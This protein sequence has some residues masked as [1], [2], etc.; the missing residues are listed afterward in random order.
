MVPYTAFYDANV[1]YPAELRN[2]LMHLALMGVFR[3]RWSAQVHEEWISNLLKQRPDLKR[4]Q[5]DRT[6]ALMDRHA[7]DALVTGY[8]HL[9]PLLTLPDMDDRHILAAA[10]QARADCIVTMNLR[11][12]PREVVSKF[13]IDAQHP[14]QFVL[15]LLDL[16][17]EKVVQAAQD[18]RLS[19][20]NPAK[21][22]LEYL[23]LLK[24]QGL[25]QTTATLRELLI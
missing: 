25:V 24:R 22:Q 4:T 2:F 10:V 5:L 21:S 13:G 9:I 20:K 23:E 19:L 14:D 3:A 7:P 18:H 15:A 11:D 17:P 1:L 8:E 6:R 16:A 12:F